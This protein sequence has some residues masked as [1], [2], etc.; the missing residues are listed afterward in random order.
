MYTP[1]VRLFNLI[2]KPVE[3]EKSNRSIFLVYQ[4]NTFMHEAIEVKF[5]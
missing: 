3:K 4:F 1:T 5:K 2:P